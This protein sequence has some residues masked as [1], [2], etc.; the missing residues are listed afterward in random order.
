MYGTDIAAHAALMEYNP[1]TQRPHGHSHTAQNH[2]TP[3]ILGQWYQIPIPRGAEPEGFENMHNSNCVLY[4][5]LPCLSMQR[6][7][8]KV[9]AQLDSVQEGI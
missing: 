6:S 4:R 5:G 9:E 7:F 2:L 8:L 1:L 3:C